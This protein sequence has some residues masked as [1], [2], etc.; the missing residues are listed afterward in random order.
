MKRPRVP[1]F[2]ETSESS[3]DPVNDIREAYARLKVRPPVS[4]RCVTRSVAVLLWVKLHALRRGTARV[5]AAVGERVILA[6]F[7][8]T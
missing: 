1:G 7:F 2:M 6:R 3:D 5:G 8:R 4:G